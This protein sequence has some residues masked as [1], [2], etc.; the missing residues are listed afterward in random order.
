MPTS[1]ATSDPA[2]PAPPTRLAPLLGGCVL[3]A[4]LVG[5]FVGLC[6]ALVLVNV[7]GLF[8]SPADAL[9]LLLLLALSFAAGLAPVGLALG[10]VAWCLRRRYASAG[11]LLR[12]AAANVLL[13]CLI[14][15]AVGQ[16]VR[17][18]PLASQSS[19]VAVLLAG[20]L[21][22][23]ALAQLGVVQRG[24][25][26]IAR[27]VLAPA[28]LAVA[29]LALA[30]A[31]Y[32]VYARTDRP[33]PVKAGSAAGTPQPPRRVIVLGLDG[34]TWDVID[35]LIAQ[36]RLPNFARLKQ[37]AAWGRL[38]TLIPTISPAIWTTVAT[39]R[40]PEVHGVDTF[41]V[42]RLSHFCREPIRKA[43]FSTGFLYLQRVYQRLGLARWEP[44]TSDIRRVPAIWNIASD[45][46]RR[47]GVIGY[48]GSW[49]PEKVHG[50][51][52]SD[53]ANPAWIRSL[54]KGESL[55]IED[56]QA[57]VARQGRMTYPPEVYLK[58]EPI[59]RTL[60]ELSLEQM[61][62]HLDARQLAAMPADVRRRI[63]LLKMFYASDLFYEQAA[64]T[65]LTERYDL[66]IVYLKTIDRVQ[67]LFWHYYQPLEAY[68]GKVDPAQVAALRDVIPAVYAHADAVV[69]R[70]LDR[71]EPGTCL[72]V[73]SDH[74]AGPYRIEPGKL[75]SGN[76]L[77][78]E[79]GIV[80]LAGDGVRA[81]TQ[82]AHASVYDIMPTLLRL[83]GLPTADDMPGHP[84]LD[85]FGPDLRQRL[86]D[87]HVASYGL[88]GAAVAAP[89]P[90]VLDA[91]S[92]FR[93]LE[94]LGYV[95]GGDDEDED[96]GPAPAASQATEPP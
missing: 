70:F 26:R 46:G 6:D 90:A 92:H 29:G 34:A 8:Q 20:T 52:V 96:A 64:E 31:T 94:A 93:E 84:L 13:I 36:G 95:G 72:L 18:L 50:F 49:P 17:H 59:A 27:I 45:A 28:C 57:Q 44:V 2:A 54:E 78:G 73:M 62:V 74:G 35:P 66:A 30:G 75:V 61:G 1:D 68:Y 82:L 10:L 86:P 79:P 85:A 16:G 53:H 25:A 42:C 87:T 39:G 19:K 15:F 40:P 55:G 81:G 88:R 7:N 83:L 65:L 22:L 47:V 9:G 77:R 12:S 24:L 71:L 76:H 80:A 89:E 67:H 14:G 21:V 11:E 60:P 56:L 38:K 51:I 4:G 91:S 23:A 63:E 43:P 33:R 41:R 3:S 32:A 37:Q 48:W 58:L 69:G 5:A